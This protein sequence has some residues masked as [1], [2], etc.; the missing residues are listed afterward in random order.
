MGG[1]STDELRKLCKNETMKITQHMQLRCRERGIKF[2]DIR[3][4]IQTGEIIEQYPEDQ[5]FPSCLVLGGSV[6]GC[7]MHVV[8]SV[9]EGFIWVITAYYP[10]KD[11]WE[12]DF[13]TRKG[14]N[15]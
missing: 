8:C 2:S 1:I 15:L 6:A 13:K 5:P 4:T 14:E 11:K 3:T 7:L 9:G 10:D 12:A